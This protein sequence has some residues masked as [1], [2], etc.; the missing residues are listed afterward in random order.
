M[1]VVFQNYLVLSGGAL[2][3]RPIP[4]VVSQYIGAPADTRM[5]A[6]LYLFETPVVPMQ[7]R[8]HQRDVQDLWREAAL[9]DYLNRFSVHDFRLVR[10]GQGTQSR[11]AWLWHPFADQPRVLELDATEPAVA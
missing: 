7:A 11:G 1:N 10:K 2:A 3:S 4:D 5:G 9:Q 6:L 8:D